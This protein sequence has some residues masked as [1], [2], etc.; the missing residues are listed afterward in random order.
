[1]LT[2]FIL[3]KLKLAKYKLLKDGTY[4]GEISS[5]KGVWV[6]GKTLKVCKK[7]LQEV[8]EDWLFL[9]VRS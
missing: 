8:L 3:S 7:E 2:E 4:F 1:M 5:L 9:K 6:N